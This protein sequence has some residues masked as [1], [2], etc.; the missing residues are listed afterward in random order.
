MLIKLDVDNGPLETATMQ[1]IRT[2]Q[3]LQQ[4]ISE[5]VYEQ[6]YDHAG[7]DDLLFVSLSHHLNSIGGVAYCLAIWEQ[8]GAC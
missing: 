5:K 7:A 2:D 8:S 6:H 1:G 3:I 4:C